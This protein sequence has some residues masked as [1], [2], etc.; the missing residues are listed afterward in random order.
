MSDY[1]YRVWVGC[2]ACY[3]GG[4]L[5]G[6]WFD[7]AEAPTSEDA[8]NEAVPSHRAHL[9]RD[10]N[11]HEEFWVMDHENSPVDGEYSPNAAVQY[12]EWLEGL[13][14]D[15]RPAFDAWL[16]H[17]GHGFDDDAVSDFESAY[18]GSYEGSYYGNNFVA[19]GYAESVIEEEVANAKAIV[20]DLGRFGDQRSVNWL[21]EKIDQ[22]SYHEDSKQRAWE[23]EANGEMVAV[24]NP[25]DS[26]IAF[27]FT[28]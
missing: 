11:P 8:F 19:S 10:V 26:S 24:Q 20:N 17:T 4:A 21:L 7:A 23:M 3:N 14:D 16:K 27:V 22:W 12:A 5:V 13:E 15:Q 2:L 18:L 25:E 1:E 28:A 9:A 6:D